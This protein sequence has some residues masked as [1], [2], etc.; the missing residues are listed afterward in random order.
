MKISDSDVLPKVIC[1]ECWNKVDAFCKF[2]EQ[3][4][5]QREEYLH[6][7]INNTVKDEVGYGG[8]IRHFLFSFFFYLRLIFSFLLHILE[9]AMSS[10]EPD[11]HRE[12]VCV[13][14]LRPIKMVIEEENESMEL[15]ESKPD[16]AATNDQGFSIVNEYDEDNEAN[17]GFF[18]GDERFES[19]NGSQLPRHISEVSHEQ[20][21]QIISQYC[22]MSCDFCET[23]FQTFQDVIGHYR[24]KHKN[25]SRGYVKCCSIKWSQNSL[26]NSHI[27]YHLNPEVYK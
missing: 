6:Q 5:A 26:F 11:I 20:Q 1:I 14:P 17:D 4:I 27:V 12:M 3:V 7:Y 19:Q 15:E 24:I 8:K 13:D 18:D 21:Q 10:I 25:Q 16:Y 23:T 9:F 22:D 2:C